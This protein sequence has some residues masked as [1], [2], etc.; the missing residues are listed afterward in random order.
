MTTTDWEDFRE[1]MAAADRDDD[2]NWDGDMDGA[3]H[4]A[5]AGDSRRATSRPEPAARVAMKAWTCLGR[6]AV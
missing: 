3:A 5:S 2:D 1:A 6:V 4:A